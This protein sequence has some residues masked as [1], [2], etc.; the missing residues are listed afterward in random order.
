MHGWL[1]WGEMGDSELK[2]KA[3]KGLKGVTERM[4]RKWGCQVFGRKSLEGWDWWW[5]W[6]W[7][8]ATTANSWDVEVLAHSTLTAYCKWACESLLCWNLHPKTYCTC[9]ALAELTTFNKHYNVCTAAFLP[10]AE[11]LCCSLTRV[12]YY[13]HIVWI[14][15]YYLLR[16]AQRVEA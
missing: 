12:V 7:G 2:K 11:L 8:D 5:E 1:W 14:L 15:I 13:L 6:Y 10:L 9:S 4:L 3:V 16:V